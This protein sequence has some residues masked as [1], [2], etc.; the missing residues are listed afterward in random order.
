MTKP[1]DWTAAIELQATDW[2]SAAK[3][4][5]WTPPV[6]PLEQVVRDVMSALGKHRPAL[7]AIILQALRE[8]RD[9]A[10]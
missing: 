6:D 8:A 9:G 5:G 4:A 7:Y 1:L 3:A 10:L 2:Q